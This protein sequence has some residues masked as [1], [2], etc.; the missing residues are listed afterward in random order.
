M[1]DEFT[2]FELAELAYQYGLQDQVEESAWNFDLTLKDRPRL[3]TLLTA[4]EHDL[5]FPQKSLAFNSD[6]TYNY[7]IEEGT[8]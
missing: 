7:S 6:L 4:Y 8:L 3:E 5:A 2:D 1:W